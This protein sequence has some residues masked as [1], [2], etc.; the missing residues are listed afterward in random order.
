MRFC[1]EHQKQLAELSD[2]PV[3]MIQHYEQRQKNINKAQTEY[4]VKLSKVLNRDIEDL[5]ELAKKE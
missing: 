5:L 4:L 2:I 3:R 1:Y